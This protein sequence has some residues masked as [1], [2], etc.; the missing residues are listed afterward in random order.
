MPRWLWP[1][2]PGWSILHADTNYCSPRDILDHLN[3]LLTFDQPIAAGFRKDKIAVI[4]FRGREGSALEAFDRLGGQYRRPSSPALSQG[5]R[6]SNYA[7]S[8]PLGRRPRPLPE[9]R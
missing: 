1:S 7:S 9:C 3:R 6:E 4:S 8:S 2:L 5:R